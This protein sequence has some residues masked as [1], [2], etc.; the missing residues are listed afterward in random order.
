[1]DRLRDPR[2]ACGVASEFIDR[3]LAGIGKAKSRP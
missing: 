3:T 2:N 1:V